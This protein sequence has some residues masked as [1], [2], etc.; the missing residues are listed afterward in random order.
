MET[1][2]CS[3]CGQ[4]K[5]TEEFYFIRTRGYRDSFCDGCRKAKQSARYKS[6][7]PAALAK[8]AAHYQK[9]KDSI[10]AR[11]SEYQKEHRA[12]ATQNHR[13]WKQ[14]QPPGPLAAQVRAKRAAD[15]ER[16]SKQNLYVASRR[17]EINSVSRARA[18]ERYREDIEASRAQRRAARAANKDYYNSL[19]HA[20]L[21][22]KAGLSGRYAVSDI[23]DILRLQN[24]KCAYCKKDIRR[25]FEV[26][27]I[28]PRALGGHNGR[29]NI[30]LTCSFCNKSKN[31]K[32]PL[33]FARWL[34]KLL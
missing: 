3:A 23:A 22:R 24:G 15:P 9:N 33:V 10:K 18:K 27:H 26:D 12:A 17:D 25:T 2:T 20:Q 8:M 16:K 30:Q 21:A 6:N 1:K 4:I 19:G 13:R 11:A 28:S 32:D 34:G 14:K 5:P 29:R 7:K 31:A